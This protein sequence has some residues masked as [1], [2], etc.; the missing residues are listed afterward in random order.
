MEGYELLGRIGGGENSEV[1][2]MR[3]RAD[4]AIVVCKKVN[5]AAM[6]SKQKHQ[7]VEEVN[8]LGEL[9]SNHIVRYYEHVLDKTGM[10]ISLV[11]EYC[12][13]GDLDSF[14]RG[15]IT[16]KRHLPE[17]SIWRIFTQVLLAV[18]EIHKRKEG[19]I[20]HR[21]IK[22]A[23]VFVDAAN[24]VKLGDFGLARRLNNEENFAKTK[25]NQTYYLSPEQL[26]EGIFTEKTDIWACGCL[27]Y[28]MACLKPPYTGE[29]QLTVAMN[30]KNSSF[31]PLPSMYSKELSRV[32][33]WCLGKNPADRPNIDELI[34]VP[35]VARR[36]REKRLS[37]NNVLLRRREE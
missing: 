25:I 4:S 27:L 29:S 21:D 24:N 30:I 6:D 26:Q 1:F 15:M 11:M 23:N 2:K 36:I 16:E 22:P 17:E 32:I 10:T 9:R 13:S 33:K 3:R 20:L 31:V 34:H 5:Y 28:Q 12:E 19:V 8:I 7:L 18:H 14:L 35:E 37:D